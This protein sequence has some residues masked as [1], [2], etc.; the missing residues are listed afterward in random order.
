MSIDRCFYFGVYIEVE[1]QIT[2]K[3]QPV[4][5]G[6]KDLALIRQTG[7]KPENCP[8]PD[9]KEGFCTVCGKGLKPNVYSYDVID[10]RLENE[11]LTYV[12]GWP[13]QPDKEGEKYIKYIISNRDNPSF[14]RHDHNSYEGEAIDVMK[15]DAAVEIGLFKDFFKKEI[16]EIEKA[17]GKDKLQFK[18]GVIRWVH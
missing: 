11:G 3:E 6:H 9:Q 12:Y 17:Y 2:F 7:N 15:L 5:C 1:N 10:H 8:L 13:N 4:H 16:A 14:H 18:F